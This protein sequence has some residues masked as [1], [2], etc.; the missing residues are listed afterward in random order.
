V[1]NLARKI[2]FRSDAGRNLQLSLQGHCQEG[3]LTGRQ[4]LLLKMF[5][6]AIQLT[7]NVFSFMYNPNHCCAQIQCLL[8]FE[9]D[10][11]ESTSKRYLV[12]T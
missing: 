6:Y 8:P 9:M 1:V 11:Q 5:Q 4:I 7:E 10:L 2:I 12:T 3:P